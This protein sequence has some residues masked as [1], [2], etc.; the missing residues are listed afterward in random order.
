MNLRSSAA[1]GLSRFA[2]LAG[3]RSA[4]A[5]KAE[6]EPDDKK[7][8]DEEEEDKASA[9]ED[10]D[11]KDE[12]KASDE[13]DEKPEDEK[14]EEKESKARADGA[15]AERARCA[16]IFASPFAANN[17]ALAATL[18]F[19]GDYSAEQ[20]AAIMQAATVG[21]PRASGLAARMA[22]QKPIQVGAE[23]APPPSADTPDGAAA[24]VISAMKLARGAK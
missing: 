9:S 12:A 14:D 4:S 10:E 2:H 18:A 8:K 13:G 20:A 6:A 22:S 7:P 23:D 16:A 11:K 3:L 21:A 15:K 17:P 24:S 5:A 1:G 19:E